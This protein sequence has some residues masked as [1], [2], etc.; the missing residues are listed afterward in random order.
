MS[1]NKFDTMNHEYENTNNTNEAAVQ[2]NSYEDI[3]SYSSDTTAAQPTAA[4]PAQ[5]Y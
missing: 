1:E 3:S 2:N 5:A 4:A